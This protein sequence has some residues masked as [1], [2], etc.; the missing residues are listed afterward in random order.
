MKMK[1]IYTTLLFFFIL[2]AANSL[3][4]ARDD[5]QNRGDRVRTERKAPSKTVERSANPTRKQQAANREETRTQ[6]RQKAE[7][8]RNSREDSRETNRQKS[9]TKRNNRE[10]SRNRSGNRDNAVDRNS[11]NNH[12]GNDMARNR[13]QPINRDFANHNDR[14][15]KNNH[16]RC[17]HCSGHG[18]MFSNDHVRKIRC[19]TCYGRGFAIGYH[20]HLSEFCPLCFAH[21][22]VRG[23]AHNRSLEQIARLETRELDRVLDL[24]SY[25]EKK[26]YRINLKYL[27]DIRH[28][29]LAYAM[30]VRDRRIM[31]VLTYRQQDWYI[32]YLRDVDTR[33]LC[34]RCYALR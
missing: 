26:I 12:P 11:D 20:T 34:D 17:P 10:S 4:F 15:F 5:N 7:I 25:Q 3:T 13:N 32:S 24:T 21:M 16:E 29:D 1:P 33:D 9:E 30:D 31:N 27:R 28:K 18:F 8:K 14:R 2:S 22:A 23:V 19:H 6:D